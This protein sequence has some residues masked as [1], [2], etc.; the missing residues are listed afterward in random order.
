MFS[1]PCL[2]VG[3]GYIAF[4]LFCVNFSHTEINN[5]MK[6][7]PILFGSWGWGLCIPCVC[8][9][10]FVLL[11][12]FL[13]VFYRLCIWL[14]LF[15]DAQS[16]RHTNQKA[17]WPLLWHSHL[18]RYSLSTC[19]VLSS[20]TL[21]SFWGD[22]KWTVSVFKFIREQKDFLKSTLPGINICFFYSIWMGPFASFCTTCY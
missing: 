16:Y 12:V 2:P 18:V 19:L 10:E 15:N 13:N 17:E 7:L 4:S 9:V 6:C 5:T 1:I 11:R 21:Q 22:L 20:H 8:R 3:K 14:Y